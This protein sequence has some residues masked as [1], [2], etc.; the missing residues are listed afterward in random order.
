MS[1]EQAQITRVAENE[2]AFR[3]ANEKL[4]A[5]FDEARS[6]ELPFLCECGDFKC[7][8]IVLV[9]LELYA[10]VREHPACFLV[11]PGHKQLE[12][13]AVVESGDGYEIIEKSGLAGEIARARWL[14]LQGL[15]RIDG[16]LPSSTAT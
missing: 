7:T 3:A 4:R 6:E 2:A 1:D 15:P 11:S 14:T 10:R 16:Q 8:Q 13:E 5:V 9:G 12:T